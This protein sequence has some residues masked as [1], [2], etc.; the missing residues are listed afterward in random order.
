M[1]DYRRNQPT[2]YG[3]VPGEPVNPSLTTQTTGK[4]TEGELEI[5][6]LLK[7]DEEIAI[8]GGKQSDG[9]PLICVCQGPERKANA[10]YI[11]LAWNN[12]ED[13]VAMC[14]ELLGLDVGGFM[15]TTS[16]INEA[17]AL[18]SRCQQ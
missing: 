5:L 3:P 15:H 6:V 13:L 18:L 16:L 10:E 9:N 4:R 11:K 2:A 17:R 12:H 7:D 1:M 8:T 14:K